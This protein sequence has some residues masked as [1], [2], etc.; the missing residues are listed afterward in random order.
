VTGC[1]LKMQANAF[2]GLD[3]LSVHGILDIFPIAVA[4]YPHSS[5]L[6]R[7]E[8]FWLT[9]LCSRMSWRGCHGSKP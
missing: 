4:S 6:R 2:P 8:L 9:V 5:H 3:K 7:K 1:S